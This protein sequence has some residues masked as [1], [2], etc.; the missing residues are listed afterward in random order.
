MAG[1]GA[2]R[3]HLWATALS[4]GDSTQHKGV[5]TL[6]TELSGALREMVQRVERDNLQDNKLH[7]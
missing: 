5:L 3:R 4:Q 2:G 1:W 7:V 6:A